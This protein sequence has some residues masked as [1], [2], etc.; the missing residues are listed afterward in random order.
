MRR[1]LRRA[2]HQR[3]TCQFLCSPGRSVCTVLDTAPTSGCQVLLSP[4]GSLPPAVCAGTYMCRPCASAPPGPPGT[5]EQTATLLLGRCPPAP[6]TAPSLLACLQYLLH[7]LGNVLG[8][9][10]TVLKCHPG[11][12]ALPE[13]LP[14]SC[15]QCHQW[16][17]QENIKL[18]RNQPIGSGL[19]TAVVPSQ[20][21]SC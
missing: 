6:S 12:A 5:K 14:P 17:G 3:Q 8:E 16:P 10:G 13:L 11:G 9:P 19:R 2:A 1:S 7:T 15:C 18:A 21:L 20:R 4:S